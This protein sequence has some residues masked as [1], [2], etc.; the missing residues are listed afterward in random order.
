ML[1]QQ[2][3]GPFCPEPELIPQAEAAHIGRVHTLP[4]SCV[5]GEGLGGLGQKHSVAP[6]HPAGSY[7]QG[8]PGKQGSL[9]AG[10]KLGIPSQQGPHG[11]VGHRAR[12]ACLEDREGEVLA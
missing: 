1:N 5:G 12:V 10:W 2:L 9:R 3:C 8:Q 11:P 7:V 6:S 4:L